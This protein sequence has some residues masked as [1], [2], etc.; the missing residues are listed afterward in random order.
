MLSLQG[1][2]VLITGLGQTSDERW[3]LAPQ[4]HRFS[5][6][7]ELSFWRKL[8]SQENE[9]CNVIETDVTSSDSV[10]ALVDQCIQKYDRIDIL[11]NIVGLS[12][13]GCPTTMSEAVWYTQV[14]IN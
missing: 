7:K 1:K 11:V 13:P 6:V 2:F 9:A 5:L 4:S 8:I 10:K 14:D 12:E 3:G